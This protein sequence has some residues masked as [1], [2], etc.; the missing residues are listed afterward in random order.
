VEAWL[1]GNGNTASRR[2]LEDQLPNKTCIYFAW[3]VLATEAAVVATKPCC[4]AA[5]AT[6]AAASG[7]PVAAT[8]PDAVIYTVVASAAYTTLCFVAMA[9][10]PR[11][12]ARLFSSFWPFIPLSLA[13]LALLISS[14]SPDT[15]QIM[16]PGSLAAGFS[17]G[18]NPQFF[19]RLEGICT[20][21]S[22]LG[23]TASWVL[24]VLVINLFAGRWCLLDGLRLGIPTSHSV[25]LCSVFG[26][27][28]LLSH[29]LTKLSFSYPTGGPLFKIQLTYSI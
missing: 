14:W 27:L 25:L 21:F 19:P 17:G 12:S 1:E 28:G 24:H 3:S 10:F 8:L 4:K 22:R 7:A 5:A 11:K 13:Y 16:M 23:V 9:L 6:A 2:I 29:F 15:L 26:P 20:L 18:F